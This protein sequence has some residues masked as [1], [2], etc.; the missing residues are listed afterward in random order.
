MKTTIR[1]VYRG[2]IETID[3][4]SIYAMVGT[5]IEDEMIK[6]LIPLEAVDQ[7]DLWQG[8]PGHVMFREDAVDFAIA[9]QRLTKFSAI[10]QLAGKIIAIEEGA[11]NDIVTIETPGLLKINGAIAKS[12]V[13]TLG[14][15][16]GDE[17][18]A[19]VNPADVILS[20]EDHMPDTE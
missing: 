10:N 7:L 5:L 2:N 20:T 14:L 8:V 1:N 11:V 9:N 19:F 13:A 3:K 6:A 12:A 18:M 4:G 15:K 17:V 16:V